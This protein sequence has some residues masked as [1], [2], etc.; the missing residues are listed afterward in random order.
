MKQLKM[1]IAVAVLGILACASNKAYAQMGVTWGAWG[2]FTSNSAIHNVDYRTGCEPL[3][4]GKSQWWVEFRNNGSQSV[5]F[6]FK[7]TDSGAP[8]PTYFGDSVNIQPGSS[9]QGWN[10]ASTPC[11]GGARIM[12]WTQNVKYGG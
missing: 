7:L 2:P 8:A 10:D 4:T 6:N 1:I 5:F 11:E 12:V 9:Q 3:S